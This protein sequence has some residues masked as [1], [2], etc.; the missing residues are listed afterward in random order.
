MFFGAG[1][2]AGPPVIPDLYLCSTGKAMMPLNLKSTRHLP[3]TPSI[4]AES[5]EGTLVLP[6]RPSYRQSHKLGCPPG[7]LMGEHVRLDCL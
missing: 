4:K 3:T 2:V 7:H 5:T 1:R 6:G